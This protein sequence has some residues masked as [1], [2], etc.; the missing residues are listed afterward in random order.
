[1]EEAYV[2][3]ALCLM[4]S[5]NKLFLATL[6]A[7]RWYLFGELY[8]LITCFIFWLNSFLLAVLLLIERLIFSF[9]QGFNL[10]RFLVLIL[11]FFKEYLE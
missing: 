6:Q 4:L 1:M 8:F 7:G 2:E 3:K 5:V 11:V 10:I 9:T